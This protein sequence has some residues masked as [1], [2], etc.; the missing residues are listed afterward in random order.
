MSTAPTEFAPEETSELFA[1]L[2]DTGKF[3]FAMSTRWDEDNKPSYRQVF[4]S[5]DFPKWFESLTTYIGGQIAYLVK[6]APTTP[7]V[8][9]PES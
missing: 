5:E 2:A 7:K 3:H 9:V 1:G 6:K 8:F 4:E